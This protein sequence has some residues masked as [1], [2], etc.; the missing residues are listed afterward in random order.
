M[1]KEDPLHEYTQT[2][3]M[4]IFVENLLKNHEQVFVDVCQQ[5]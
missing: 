1:R 4:N 5:T 2:K 3:A